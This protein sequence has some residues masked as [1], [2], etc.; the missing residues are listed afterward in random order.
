MG[1]ALYENRKGPSYPTLVLR[2][3]YVFSL[4]LSVSHISLH[5][6]RCD[7]KL[8]WQGDLGKAGTWNQH[9]KVLIYFLSTF[10]ISY[11]LYPCLINQL[12]AYYLY[13]IFLMNFTHPILF[14]FFYIAEQIV[15][16]LY[17]KYTLQI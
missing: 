5:T 2:K 12:F 13:L 11:E 10:D 17:G 16:R 6:C 9:M 14:S 7:Y 4:S 3:V 15:F 1:L 8:H